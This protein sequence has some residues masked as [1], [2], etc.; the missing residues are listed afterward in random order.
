MSID[1]LLV[2]DV[3]DR[4]QL[5]LDLNFLCLN[6]LLSASFWRTLMSICIHTLGVSDISLGLAGF[7][8]ELG[9]MDTKGLWIECTQLGGASRRLRDHVSKL[10]IFSAISL[11]ERRGALDL[12]PFGR[13]IIMQEN[14]FLILLGHFDVIFRGWWRRN[15]LELIFFVD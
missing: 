10:L 7:Q 4:E 12:L 2:V 5:L 1:A 8:H 15:L 14:N 11:Q 3:I 13:R 9:E 6:L